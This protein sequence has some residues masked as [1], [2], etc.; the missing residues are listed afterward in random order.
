MST[1]SR[2][3]SR[4]DH[5]LPG[6]SWRLARCPVGDAEPKDRADERCAPMVRRRL[7]G[8]ARSSSTGR[9]AL[10]KEAV[11]PLADPLLRWL[12]ECSRHG[13]GPRLYVASTCANVLNGFRPFRLV[14]AGGADCCRVPGHR[15]HVS[16]P[17]EPLE[18]WRRQEGLE[19]EVVNA[20]TDRQVDE[21]SASVANASRT[22]V[23]RSKPSGMFERWWPATIVTS[24]A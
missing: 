4:P 22:I 18:A 2:R 11:E 5:C 20:K 10:R 14:P 9:C 24:R 13:H 21:P 7:S 16:Y 8:Q 12:S 19:G 3:Q 6:G 1:P 17:R 15:S 23:I